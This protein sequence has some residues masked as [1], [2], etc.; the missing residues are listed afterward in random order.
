LRPYLEHSARIAVNADYQTELR[1]RRARQKE[2]DAIV[3]AAISAVAKAVADTPPS[4]H[5]HLFYGAS[6]IH[7]KN[8]VAWFIFRTDHDQ[9]Q[10][11]E[12]GLCG[13]IDA[14]TRQE[15]GAQGYP[16]EALQRIHVGFTSHETIQREAGGD[17]WRYFK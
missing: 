2:L 1:R 10:A 3:H 12:N 8:L 16:S 14:L 4:L 6:A 5:T 7:P 13:R 11:G 15:L 9:Q 17:Y